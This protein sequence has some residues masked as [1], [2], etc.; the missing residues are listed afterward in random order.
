MNVWIVY[1]CVV[2]CVVCVLLCVLCTV[3][4]AFVRVVTKPSSITQEQEVGG[5]ILEAQRISKQPYER[6]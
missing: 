4:Y 5:H 3:C 2:V 6:L 1:V